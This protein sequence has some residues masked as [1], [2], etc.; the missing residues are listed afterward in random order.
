[1][2]ETLTRQKHIL[3]SSTLFFLYYIID[4]RLAQSLPELSDEVSDDGTYLLKSCCT[5]F[6][7]EEKLQGLI[8]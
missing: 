1:M 5:L 7:F 3:G 4:T 8:K 6:V 2:H